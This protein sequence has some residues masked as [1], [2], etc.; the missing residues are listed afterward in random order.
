MF[1]KITAA[2]L[3]AALV[4]PGFAMAETMDANDDGLVSMSEFQTM[5]PDLGADIFSIIDTNADGALSEDEI[6]AARATGTLPE[7]PTDD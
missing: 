5:Y 3:A 6:E 7:A 1:K 4:A 2:T